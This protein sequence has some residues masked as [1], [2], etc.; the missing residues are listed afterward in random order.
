MKLIH[1]LSVGVATVGMTC[2]V[3]YAAAINTAPSDLISDSMLVAQGTAAPGGTGSGS[4]GG[5]GMGS[6]NTGAG[7]TSGSTDPSKGPAGT[8]PEKAKPGMGMD[9]GPAGNTGSNSGRTGTSSGSLGSSSG[10]TGGSG[11][12]GMSGSGSGSSSGAGGGGK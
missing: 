3:G 9:T 10:P 7:T 5:M 4:A 2:F 11:P 1:M 12:S 8:F 6:G